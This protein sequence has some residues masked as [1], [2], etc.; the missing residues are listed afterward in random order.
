MFAGLMST[1]VKLCDDSS[2]VHK[3]TR[4]GER[5]RRRR[6]RQ[7][8]VCRADS[9]LT[10]RWQKRVRRMRAPL[11]SVRTEERLWPERAPLEQVPRDA[12][13]RQPTGTFARQS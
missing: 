5:G 4:C 8:S 3:F 2:S 1:I 9:R 12:P 6:G 10:A 11:E 7:L 13:N